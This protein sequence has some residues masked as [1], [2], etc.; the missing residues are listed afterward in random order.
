M[1]P[2]T[3]Y[4]AFKKIIQRYNANKDEQLKLPSIPLHGLRHTSATLL[5]SSN[6]DS[7]RFRKD[8]GILAQAQQWTYMRMD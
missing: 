5:I 2:D 8:L 4:K 7:E 6:T 3:P 1:H